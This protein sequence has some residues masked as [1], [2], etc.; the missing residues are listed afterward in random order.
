MLFYGFNLYHLTPYMVYLWC[1][2]VTY[3][4]KFCCILTDLHK[5]KIVLIIIDSLEVLKKK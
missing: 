5:E 3:I 2:Y 4:Y 1:I